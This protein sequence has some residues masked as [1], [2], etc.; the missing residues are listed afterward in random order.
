LVTTCLLAVILFTGP[1]VLGATPFWIELPLLD[2]TALL[3]VVQGLRLAAPLLPAAVRRID[4]IDLSVIAFVFYALARWLTSPAEYVSRMEAMAVVAYGG[5]FLT[6]R[7]GMSNRRYCMVLL[8]F[9]VALG[10]GEMFLGF[11]INHHPN[12]YPFEWVGGREAAQGLRWAGTFE[13]PNHYASLLVMAFAAAVA[14]GAFSK[15]PWPARI[16]LF[17]VAI[18]LI[19]GVVC[20]G[21]RGGCLALAAAIAG[22]AVM[23]IRNGTMPWW[24]PVTGAAVLT[25]ITVLIFTLSPVAWERL[26]HTPNPM[27]GGKIENEPR[28]GLAA[29]ALRMARDHPL[30]GTG[31]A[32]FIY[33]HPHYQESHLDFKPEAAHD[34]Y[35]NCLDDYGLVGFAI[36][37]FFV[38]AVTLKFFRPLDVDHRW[39]DRVLVST[40]FAAWCALLVHSWVDYNL[41]IPANALIFFSLTG[42]AIGRIKDERNLHWSQV[43]LVPLG[44]WVGWGLVIVSLAFGFL[45]TRTM[46]SDWAYEKASLHSSVISLGDSIA[47]A[48]EAL[49]YAPG[50]AQALLLL[51]DSHREMATLQKS[52]DAEF[53]EAQAALDA[54]TK[55]Q[56]A[57]PLDDS[58]DDRMGLTLDLMQK[59][60]DALPYYVAAVNSQ[61]HNGY[62]WYLLSNHDLD[63]GDLQAATE[64]MEQVRHCFHR[65]DWFVA[66]D[67]K[68][69]AILAGTNPQ[70]PPAA[71]TPPPLP[72]TS[73]SKPKGN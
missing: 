2:L 34:D 71:L 53:A 18:M 44:R 14:L 1:L 48:E 7:Y 32:T 70:T 59:Y 38:S 66:Y 19:V 9:L 30:F 4:A 56:R 69:R 23:G 17:Y 58:V 43:S 25:A 36:A 29:E 6:C 8:Y 65:G 73:T 26:A 3:L 67:K 60:S 22:F 12:W 68:R 72:Q 31:P 51:G 20:S 49:A 55:A 16:V 61:H 15:L 63:S 47:A 41:H 33:V 35:L 37:M 27:T 39:Q 54:Y 21:S 11:Y 46:L 10:V 42:L 50:N 45:V 13:S 57:N 62:Y 24:V 5:V 40:G 52:K 28:V 64:A